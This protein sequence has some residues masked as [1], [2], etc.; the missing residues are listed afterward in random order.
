MEQVIHTVEIK[1]LANGPINTSHEQ[2]AIKHTSRYQR[3]LN[4]SISYTRKMGRN[5]PRL[6]FLREGYRGCRYSMEKSKF[7]SK[8][9]T[10]HYCETLCCN[11][12]SRIH[13]CDEPT[14]Q[15]LQNFCCL[16][17]SKD[18]NSISFEKKRNL[19]H[20]KG[21]SSSLRERSLCL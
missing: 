3:S 6:I 4:S 12:S 2:R 15:P 16:F 11:R 7:K 13:F 10:N 8:P 20:P 17:T 9:N 5:R 21:S 1:L 14:K 18:W 19:I